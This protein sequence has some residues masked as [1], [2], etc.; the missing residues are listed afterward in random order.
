MWHIGFGDDQ[1]TR[2]GC[3][4]HRAHDLNQGMSL[5][6]MHAAGA[7]LLPHEPDRIEADEPRTLGAVV[8]QYVQNFEQ[9]VW[10]PVVQVDLVR[11]EGGPDM[12]GPSGGLDLGQERQGA[13]PHD[14]RVVGRR[15]RADEVAVERGD[16]P[17]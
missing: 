1:R 2:G 6:Q 12:D 7:R 17:L 15:I 16:T 3:L 13:R 5:R 8:Q 14:R 10:V 11:A 9:K 4:D